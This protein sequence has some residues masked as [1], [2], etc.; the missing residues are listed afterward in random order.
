[1][2]TENSKYQSLKSKVNADYFLFTLYIEKC[3][4]NKTKLNVSVLILFKS[5]KKASN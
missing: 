4:L 2:R 5:I 3:L 1:M